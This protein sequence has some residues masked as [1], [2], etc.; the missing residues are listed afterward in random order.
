MAARCPY[1]NG[2][3]EFENTAHL[4]LDRLWLRGLIFDDEGIADFWLNRGYD[5][6]NPPPRYS[7]C[8]ACGGTGDMS[9]YENP[10]L[11]ARVL[12]A[13]R[14]V[15]PEGLIGRLLALHQR[16]RELALV[17]A[18]YAGQYYGLDGELTADVAAW[19][20]PAQEVT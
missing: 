11:E 19:P 6:D 16:N 4:E 14:A 12:A 3:G 9:V 18:R 15:N 10:A 20:V 7:V 2:A 13:W 17:L 8:N 5:P 1:C